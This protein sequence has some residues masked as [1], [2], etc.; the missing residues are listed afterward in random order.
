MAITSLVLQT[1]TLVL[2]IVF[3]VLVFKDLIVFIE[4]YSDGITPDFADAI[5]QLYSPKTRVILLV[6]SLV[7]LADLVLIIMIAVETS[8]LKSK[9]PMIFLLVGLA[10]SVLKLVGLIMTLIQCNK[11]LKRGDPS[12][13]PN[14]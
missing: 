12:E 4:Q 14:N 7:G 1:V 2:N 3:I 13:T 6:N 10:V 11:Q 8:K 9:L 5:S